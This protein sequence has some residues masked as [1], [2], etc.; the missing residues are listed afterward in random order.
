[1]AKNEAL[2]KELEIALS[3]QHRWRRIMSVS[4]FTSTALAIIC[5]GAATIVAGLGNSVDAA[6]LA[7]VATILFGLE[8][9]M[10]FREKWTHHLGIS[11]QLQALRYR[12]LFGDTSDAEAA[13][14]MGEIISNYA[15][16]LPVAPGEPKLQRSEAAQ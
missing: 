3:R 9:A 8:K 7:G 14:G 12:Y 1:M 5:S 10:L 2:I 11:A 15:I 4:Y 6:N 16:N 13:A